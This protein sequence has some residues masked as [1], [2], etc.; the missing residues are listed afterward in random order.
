MPTT[1]TTNLSIGLP[2]RMSGRPN[3]RYFKGEYYAM[4][5]P[6]HK[7]VGGY[8]YK[9]ITLGLGSNRQKALSKANCIILAKETFKEWE[10]LQPQVSINSSNEYEIDKPMYPVVSSR[11]QYTIDEICDFYYAIKLKKVLNGKFCA[12]SL[13]QLQTYLD[14]IKDFWKGYPLEY[15]D[16]GN[17]QTHIDR[18]YDLGKINKNKFDDKTC[19]Q[20][21]H[22]RSAEA[23]RSC[24]FNLLKVAKR[25]K[26]INFEYNPVSE[27]DLDDI[28][29]TVKRSRCSEAVYKSVFDLADNNK[30]KHYALGFELAVVT[31]LRLTDGLLIRKERG[32]DWKERVKAFRKNRNYGL[33]KRL[34]FQDLQGL[35]PYSY[36]DNERQQIV[37][38]QQKTGKIFKIPFN[39][40][41]SDNLPTVGEI[42]TKISLTCTADSEFLFHHPKNIGRAIKGT[43]IHPYGLSRK[44]RILIRELD[45]D[46]ENLSPPTI[47]EL[48][49]L[50][51]RLLKVYDENKHEILTKIKCEQ[52]KIKT[53]TVSSTIDESIQNA[54]SANDGIME[55]LGQTDR[56]IQFRYLDQRNL[57]LDDCAGFP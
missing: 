22:G 39:H 6:F 45:L 52:P 2:S 17:I 18:Y 33:T 31:K 27:T 54:P 49:S 28:D 10:K 11:K 55:S 35:A 40:R 56:N 51:A 25:K 29:T 4:T 42:I 41:V 12:T 44:F 1:P 34:S 48:R 38:F 14:D 43:A 13:S 32:S 46:W 20:E 23:L 7:V 57:I 19:V 50:G 3:V 26:L 5:N 37:V 21:S 53:D 16:T 9:N 36:I 8:K 15:F 24:Y 47:G 30:N